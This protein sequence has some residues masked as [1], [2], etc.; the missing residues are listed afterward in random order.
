MSRNHLPVSEAAKVAGLTVGRVYQ[1]L[2]SGEMKGTRW[3]S[4]WQVSEKEAKKFSK[5]AK[6][7]RPRKAKPSE[8]ESDG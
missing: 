8:G 5:P 1:L 6:T 4:F 7:G 3:G 2:R